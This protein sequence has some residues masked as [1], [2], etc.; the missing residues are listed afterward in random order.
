MP[1]DAKNGIRTI[2]FARTVRWIGWGFGEPLIPVFIALFATTFAGEGLIRSLYD[3]MTLLA[4]PVIGWLADRYPARTLILTAL[5]LYPLVGLGYF[6]AGV[7]GLGIFIVLTRLLNGAVWGLENISVDTYYR[8][9][10]PSGQ[11]GS[12]FGYID[13]LANLGWVAA[14]LSGIWLVKVF[15]IHYLLLA[16][17]PCTILA[18]L[19]ARRAPS[20]SLSSTVSVSSMLAAYT[21]VFSRFASWDKKLFSLSAIVFFGEMINTLAS[22]FLPIYVYKETGD[23]TQAIVIAIIAT[24]PSLFGYHLGKISDAIGEQRVFAVGLTMLLAALVIMSYFPQ[25]TVILIAIFIIEVVLELIHLAQKSSVTKL[26]LPAIWGERGSTMQGISVL[27]AIAGP[28]TIGI[29]FDLAGAP[30][31]FLILAG[32]AAGLAVLALRVFRLPA[33]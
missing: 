15:P 23:P 1:E 12:A 25:W 21:T 2:A 14:A 20:D 28:I 9:M 6:F 13:M 5:V 26:S 29:V 22:F 31:T 27:G 33:P 24:I 10:V 30:I 16:I 32:I 18:F 17:V 7:T 4:L 3:V 19:I 11:L 8:R